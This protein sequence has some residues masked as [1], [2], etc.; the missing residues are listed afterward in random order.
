MDEPVALRTNRHWRMAVWALR[1]GYVAL[2]VT[3]VGVIVLSSG[4]TPWILVIGIVGWL[5]AAAVTLTGV[6]EAR[7]ELPEPRPGFWPMRW[8]ILHDTVHRRGDV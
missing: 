8:M 7:S 3:V 6:F 4:S 2:A 5:V 1:F